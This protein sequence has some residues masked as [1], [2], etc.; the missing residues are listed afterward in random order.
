[1]GRQIVDDDGVA[2]LERRPQTLFEI[3][4]EGGS[5]HRPIHHEGRDHLVMAKPG[6]EGDRLPMPLR[7]AADQPLAAPAAAAK[8]HHVGRG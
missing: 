7:H 8:P 4:Q 3:S 6:Y 2:A 1:M 5:G